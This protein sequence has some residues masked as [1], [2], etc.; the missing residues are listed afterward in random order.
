MQYRGSYT[1]G[2]NDRNVS[3]QMT[4][5]SR[6]PERAGSNLLVKE[7]RYDRKGAVSPGQSI[8]QSDRLKSESNPGER[9]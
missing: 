6:I 9:K 1:Q 7:K 3:R 5:N 8:V 4:A 2:G